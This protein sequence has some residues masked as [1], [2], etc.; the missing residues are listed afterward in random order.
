MMDSSDVTPTFKNQSS[1]IS[2]TSAKN[3]SVKQ[4]SSNLTII[5]I[6]K[7]TGTG[8]VSLDPNDKGQIDQVMMSSPQFQRGTTFKNSAVG[9]SDNVSKAISIERLSAN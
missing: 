9:T 7:E 2:K 1:T 6:N 5:D 3:F 8:D 4:H